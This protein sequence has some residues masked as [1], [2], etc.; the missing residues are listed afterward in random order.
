MEPETLILQL[1]TAIKYFDK[2]TS[3]IEEADEAFAPKEG[4]YTASQQVAHVAQTIDWFMEGAFGPGWDLDFAAHDKELREVTSIAAARDWVKRAVA[5]AV[6]IIGSKS[7]EE[8]AALMPE[9]PIMG[10][11]PYGSVVGGIIEHTSHHRGSL[12]VYA[13]LQGKE[14]PMPYM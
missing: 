11:L 2:S 3:W 7:S 4:L 1:E 10:G 9:G 12:A 5:N 13:R 8:L 14:P 6:E